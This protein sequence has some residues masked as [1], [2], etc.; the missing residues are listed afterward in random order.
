MCRAG[1]LTPSVLCRCVL[2]GLPWVQRAAV[3]R[4][5][6]PAVQLGAS[7]ALQAMRERT[8]VRGLCTKGPPGSALMGSPGGHPPS[9]DAVAPMHMTR[10]GGSSLFTGLPPEAAAALGLPKQGAGVG[11]ECGLDAATGAGGHL[12]QGGQE[13]AGH[14]MQAGRTQ[15]MGHEGQNQHVGVG[16]A[17]YGA[18]GADTDTGGK[19]VSGEMRDSGNQAAAPCSA[20]SGGQRQW[21]RSGQDNSAGGAQAGAQVQGMQA[22]SSP[23][24]WSD[25]AAASLLPASAAAP[26]RLAMGLQQ[27]QQCSHAFPSVFGPRSHVDGEGC[28]EIFDGQHQ[29][30]RAAMVLETSV[31][32]LD[33]QDVLSTHL[34]TIPEDDEGESDEDECLSLAITDSW[35]QAPGLPVSPASKG[36]AASDAADEVMAEAGSFVPHTSDRG[37]HAAAVSAAAVLETATT[38]VAGAPNGCCTVQPALADITNTYVALSRRNDTAADKTKPR[39]AICSMQH[40]QQQRIRPSAMAQ[41]PLQGLNPEQ[42]VR[43]PQ[44]G[45]LASRSQ[46]SGGCGSAVGMGTTTVSAAANEA[47]P[48]LSNLQ[49]LGLKRGRDAS[50]P[51]SSAQNGSTSPTSPVSPTS[52][53]GRVNNGRAQQAVRVQPGP[54]LVSSPSSPMFRGTRPLASRGWARVPAFTR[55]TRHRLSR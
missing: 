3:R 1:L 27:Q 37:S 46:G 32:E 22:D 54:A 21:R 41:A 51:E 28:T 55:R 13:G 17:P 15:V 23:P 49:W 9:M 10:A 29:D 53:W 43:R 14:I 50:I 40:G 33:A 31:L 19:S 36:G 24:L 39:P 4:H 26:T 48:P 47:Q 12:R 30:A 52:H 11:A 25:P 18:T 6:P 45:T 5:L 34:S 7:P 35:G 2:S 44:Q 16:G 42:S 20:A 8:P 38:C